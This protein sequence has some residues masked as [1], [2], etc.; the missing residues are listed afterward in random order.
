MY[1][2]K[3]IGFISSFS[4]FLF[5]LIMSK[6]II[7][8][9]LLFM[10]I[11][12]TYTQVSIGTS[13]LH[14]S[15][16]END[17]GDIKGKVNTLLLNA[18]INLPFYLNISQDRKTIRMW[19]VFVSG[20]Y[21]KM[22]ETTSPE[23]YPFKKILNMYTGVSHYRTLNDKWSLSV[24]GGM[25]VCT[26][27]TRFSQIGW[28]NAMVYALGTAIYKVNNNLD[29]GGGLILTN[30]FNTPMVFPSVYVKWKGD[31]RYSFLLST[32]TYDIVSSLGIQVTPYLRLS[33]VAD[34]NRISTPLEDENDKDYYYSFNYLT[35]GIRPEIKVSKNI[36]IPIE[37]GAAF[38][39]SG[40][41]KKRK[42][43]NLLKNDD[44][45]SFSTAP[46]ISV[47]LRVGM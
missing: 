25:G 5:F 6:I 37:I 1:I 35:T 24:V 4:G 36:T 29:I 2:S 22:N 8:G 16:F 3:I 32:R 18:N 34:Y 20:K 19:S 10:F 39:G 31:G 23:V 44:S 21:M 28:D 17:N 42:L 15:N 47:S 43:S 38:A 30:A 14:S 13:Y 26:D 40:A 27:D 41:Y 45:Y 33:L 11:M 7:T 46:Y 9:L 12:P